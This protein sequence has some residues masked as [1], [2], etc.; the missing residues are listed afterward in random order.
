MNLVYPVLR[1][2]VS[3]GE[4]VRAVVDSEDPSIADRAEATDLSPGPSELTVFVDWGVLDCASKLSA[5]CELTVHALSVLGTGLIPVCTS[6]AQYGDNLSVTWTTDESALKEVSFESVLALGV[7]TTTEKLDCNAEKENRLGR[8]PACE[9]IVEL[10]WAEKQRGDESRNNNEGDLQTLLACDTGIP[11]F[12]LSQTRKRCLHL[13]PPINPKVFSQKYFSD[14]VAGGTCDLSHSIGQDMALHVPDCDS[15]LKK[16]LWEIA[17]NSLQAVNPGSFHKLE[18]GFGLEIECLTFCADP[19][20]TGCFTKKQEFQKFIMNLMHESEKSDNNQYP[21]SSH[22]CLATRFRQLLGRICKWDLIKEIQM[23]FFP[24]SVARDI[25]AQEKSICPGSE[26]C[27]EGEC[28]C[29]EKNAR[30]RALLG[31]TDDP[32]RKSDLFPSEFKS[33]PP[34]YELSFSHPSSKT[35][36]PGAKFDGDSEEGWNGDAEAEVRVLF[37]ILKHIGVSMPPITRLGH[38][39]AGLHVHV[40]V[41]NPRALGRLLSAKEI[42]AVFL[43]WVRFEPVT[44]RWTKPWK[45]RDRSAAPL[46]PSGPEFLFDEA[47][48]AQG[49]HCSDRDS[50]GLRYNLPELFWAAH[51]VMRA[52]AESGEDEAASNARVMKEVLLNTELLGRTLGRHCSLNLQALKTHGTLEFRRMDGSL[53]GEWVLLWAHFCVAFVDAFCDFQ[54]FAAP[55]LCAPS[56]ALGLQRL[57]EVQAACMVPTVGLCGS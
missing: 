2:S 21:W 24:P 10:Q 51:E 32:W 25:Y 8:A 3:W 18:R 5:D 27:H 9:Y 19:D 6:R 48:W 40:N 26:A 47:V 14:L 11:A 12:D 54:Q 53:D 56:P 52:S 42:L 55:F 46:W 34:P 31:L 7:N 33:P 28:K 50:G 44:R 49:S 16:V 20:V 17:S 37:A 22:P 57:R 29:A 45:W 15:D 23:D 38:S 39:S 4:S 43:A 41:C 35:D 30:T 13:I 36:L 1:P